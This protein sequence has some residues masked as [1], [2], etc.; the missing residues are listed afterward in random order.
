MNN[1]YAAELD[2][3]F[4]QPHWLRDLSLSAFFIVG[5]LLSSQTIADSFQFRCFSDMGPDLQTLTLSF[6]RR[7]Y[8]NDNIET[9]RA[10]KSTSKG[11]REIV[12]NNFLRWSKQVTPEMIMK[13][14]SLYGPKILG[15]KAIEIST[16]QKYEI[17]E[18]IE[19][20]SWLDLV[21]RH[22]SAD[23]IHQIEELL[24]TFPWLKAMSFKFRFL[25][26]YS[27]L[28]FKN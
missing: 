17:E 20:F 8:Y 16:D 27:P 10:V 11:M 25:P 19:S 28:E 5:P 24:R 14:P 23:Q 26:G 22:T 7:P 1:P 18:L 21:R 15:D 4:R 12:W 3:N 2:H 6:L 13:F 9:L